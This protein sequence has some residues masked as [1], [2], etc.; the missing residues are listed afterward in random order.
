M[1][2]LKRQKSINRKVR[3]VLRK[4]R[5][6]PIAIGIIHKILTLCTLRSYP[7]KVD[8]VYFA[9][10]KDFFNIPAGG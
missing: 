4:D 1:G 8:F 5:K 10:K 3:K 7:A 9:V 6:V 2:L